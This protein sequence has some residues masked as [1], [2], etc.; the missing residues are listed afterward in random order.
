MEDGL[1]RF[2][3]LVEGPTS[4]ENIRKPIENHIFPMKYGGVPASLPILG[5]LHL[6]TPQ[7]M[8]QTVSERRRLDENPLGLIQRQQLL[9]YMWLKLLKNVD[10]ALQKH[11]QCNACSISKS[12]GPAS[13]KP[14]CQ[15]CNC[16]KLTGSIATPDTSPR[17]ES[18]SF[19]KR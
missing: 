14:T 5:Q 11:Q 16:R 1:P 15:S 8:R 17:W 7:A 19:S 10:L 2:N 6:K 3:G 18:R 13:L 9:D 12:N 4:T